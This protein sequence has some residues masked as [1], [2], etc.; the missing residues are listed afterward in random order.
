MNKT[1]CNGKCRSCT[2]LGQYPSDL[3]LCDSCG[4]EIEP[5]EGVEV[6]TEI[7]KNGQHYR[8]TVT[9]CCECYERFYLSDYSDD[10]IF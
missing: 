9:V 5:G 8:K 7:V 4:R 3:P 2:L 10:L 6:E 1:K